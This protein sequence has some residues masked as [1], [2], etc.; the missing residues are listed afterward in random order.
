MNSSLH[1]LNRGIITRLDR[2]VRGRRQRYLR[3]AECPWIWAFAWANQLKYRRHWE[4]HVWRA[5]I[6]SICAE[7]HID[8][9]EC[10]RVSLEPS[11]LDGNCSSYCR[12]ESPI[13]SCSHSSTWIHPLHAIRKGIIRDQVITSPSRISDHRMSVH[14]SEAGYCRNH[15]YY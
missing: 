4:R 11:G 10:R 2:D 7:A 12:P 14:Q 8:V 1:H 9:E 6:W 3:Q 13:C 5:V 15:S